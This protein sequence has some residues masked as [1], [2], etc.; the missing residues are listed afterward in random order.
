M[1]KQLDRQKGSA[2]VVIIIALIIVLLGI[3]G[4]V[5]WQNFIQSKNSTTNST[6]IEKSIPVKTPVTTQ[7]ISIAEEGIKFTIPSTYPAITYKYVDQDTQLFAASTIDP[8]ASS[9]TSCQ[10]AD[11]GY[12]MSLTYVTKEN[13]VSF[14]TDTTG[15]TL[16]GDKYWN[17]GLTNPCNSVKTNQLIDAIVANIVAI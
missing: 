15:Y 17:A 12:F 10:D 3:L 14:K 5:F 1:L 2:H 4:F 13:A 11:T 8:S 7:T 6:S 9:T 16:V